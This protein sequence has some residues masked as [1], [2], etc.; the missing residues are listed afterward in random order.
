MT[1]SAAA[2]WRTAVSTAVLL[3]AACATERTGSGP[4][5]AQPPVAVTSYD[6]AGGVQISVEQ[7][8]AAPPVQLTL[9]YSGVR[10]RMHIVPSESG[11]KY[12]NEPNKLAWLSK[13]EDASLTSFASGEALA[14]NCKARRP[15]N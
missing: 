12:V 13:S 10:Y 1:G 14:K 2:S 8:G 4:E 5:P 15:S 11:G 3:V 9:I 6:C 7:A